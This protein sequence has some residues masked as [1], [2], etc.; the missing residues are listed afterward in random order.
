MYSFKCLLFS[1]NSPKYK[2][3]FFYPQTRAEAAR[4]MFKLADVPFE[5]I[6]IFED[7]WVELKPSKTKSCN[8]Q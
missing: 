4:M 3:I 2:L 5:D 1:R 7:E 6:R 8:N